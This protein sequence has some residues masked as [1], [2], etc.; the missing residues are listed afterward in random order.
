M[1]VP[2][3][4]AGPLLQEESDR[5]E[6]RIAIKNVFIKVG[7]LWFCKK[8]R[9]QSRNASG[10]ACGCTKPQVENET[11][12]SEGAFSVNDAAD[13]RARDEWSLPSKP[14]NMS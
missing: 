12:N 8:A 14:Y 9:M 2:L 4:A 6:N 10:P 1:A 13:F 3:R 5:E 7:Y 11:H